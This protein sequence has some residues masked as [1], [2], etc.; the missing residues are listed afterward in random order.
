M[1][2]D[3]VYFVDQNCVVE[4]LDATTN[5]HSRVI[6]SF[7]MFADKDVAARPS[8]ACNGSPLIDGD[9]L[10]VTTSNGV[11]RI[12]ER[13]IE[14]DGKRKCMAPRAPTLIALDKWTG[15]LLARDTAPIAPNMLHG[16]W[17]SPSKATVQGR[18]LVFL[19]GGDGNC[20]AFDALPSKVAGTFHVPSA[21]S[22]T[23]ALPAPKLATLKIAWSYDCNPPDHRRFGEMDMFVHYT[24]GDR[25]RADSLNKD[26]DG[27]FVGLNEIIA[28]PVCYKDRIYIAIGRDPEHG[29]G[30]GALHCI[31]ATK[32]G[33]VTKLA[34]LWTYEGLD[35]T[36]CT[37]YRS[38]KACF[39]SPMWPG[40]CT[41]STP[42]Q[43]R[44][45]GFTN[46]TV[47]RSPRR[48]SPMA[49]STCPR[50]NI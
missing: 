19:G 28:T 3:R 16:Q 38:A 44:S 14:E 26:N 25:R 5:S 29:R 50:Q 9:V 32:S 40:G 47:R 39:I 42:R 1:D 48:W 43:A 17:S 23:S 13:P 36:L 15:R 37:R 4:C 33:D 7:D 21:V 46:R 30:R 49:R 41:V 27:S 2:G 24:L 10:Y 35:R 22:N 20:Y 8:D 31:D 11:D 34:K 6:W 12:V 45:I 18:K